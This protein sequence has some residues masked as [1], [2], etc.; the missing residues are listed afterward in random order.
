MT[1]IPGTRHAVR[2]VDLKP[3]SAG[4]ALLVEL[5]RGGATCAS[6]GGMPSSLICALVMAP[7]KRM[8]RGRN[9]GQN[10]D[11]IEIRDAVEQVAFREALA[12]RD[13]ALQNLAIGGSGEIDVEN[14]TPGPAEL[15]NLSL[16]HADEFEVVARGG[17][18]LR[19]ER[20]RVAGAE[21]APS[22]AVHR[23]PAH[24]HTLAA[25]RKYRC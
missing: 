3:Q 20:Q 2:V 12:H 25:A 5:G 23:I 7:S 15:L 13:M 4:A 9:I 10:P 8:S 19:S 14:F 24:R 17:Q 1:I 11:A 16:A 22:S 18:L 6:S 21:L